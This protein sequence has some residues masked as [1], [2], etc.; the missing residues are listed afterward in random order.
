MYRKQQIL[1]QVNSSQNFLKEH[2]RLRCQPLKRLKV[3]SQGKFLQVK[4]LTTIRD[5]PAM[6]KRVTPLARVSLNCHFMS[7]NDTK[8]TSSTTSSCGT[9]KFSILS[10][11]Y[12]NSYYMVVSSLVSRKTCDKVFLNGHIWSLDCQCHGKH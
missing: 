6:S 9:R 10:E 1:P 5:C 8:R 4:I 2:K 12:H 11:I 3:T 7:I